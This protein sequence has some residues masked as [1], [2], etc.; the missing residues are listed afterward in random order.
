MYKSIMEK[1][2]KARVMPKISE[3]ERQALEAG[4][5]WIESQ[6]FSGQPNFDEIF[7]QPYASL[8]QREQDFIRHKLP[9]L[10]ALVDPY[11]LSRTKILPEQAV[12]LMQEE[13]FYSFLIPREYGGLEFSAQAISTI[14][15]M[16]AAH[17]PFLSTFVV[18]P[19]SLGAAELL[20]HYGREDQKQ[21]YLPKLA[22]GTYIPC[23]ALTEPLAGS[24]AASIQ[25]QG[26]LFKNQQGQL[27][28]RLNFSKRYI[29]LA[30]IANLISLAFRLKDP[31]LLL[32]KQ[33]DLGITVALVHRGA[34]GLEMGRHHQPI[35]DAFY[36]GP[37]QGNNV[38]IDAHE[39]IGGIDYVGQGWRMLMEQLAGGRAIS[40]PAGAVGTMRMLAVCAGSYAR[41]RHQFDMPIANMEGVQEKLADLAS[42]AYLAEGARIFA[43]SA[44]DNGEKPPIVSAIWKAYLTD[45]S[46]KQAMNAM[47][48]LA[49][50]GVMQGPHNLVGAS[51]CSAPVSIT[52]EGANIMT[53]SLI[54]FGQGAIRCHPFAMNLVDALENEDEKRFK[55]I[56]NHW[57]KSIVTN[58]LRLIVL[59]LTRGHCS[60]LPKINGLQQHLKRLNWASSRFAFLTNMALI[61]VGGKLK[62]RQQLTGYFSDALAWQLLALSSIR[63]YLAEGEIKEDLPLVQYACETALIHIQQAYES[64]YANFSGNKWFSWL[65]RSFGYVFVRLNPLVGVRRDR[66]VAQCAQA[67]TRSGPQMMRIAGELHLPVQRDEEAE[68]LS[69]PLGLQRLLSAFFALEKIESLELIIKQ[70]IKEQKLPKGNVFELAQQ[71]V[72]QG[73]ITSEDKAR[74]DEANRLMMQAI[75]VDSFTPQEF[76]GDTKIQSAPY[77]NS[78]HTP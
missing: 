70:G 17:S 3:T 64:I 66:L 11:L 36:N 38:E 72:N 2:N 55:V 68:Q 22:N 46:R 58:T 25:A 23:F 14:M 77:F 5:T 49:G 12:R 33:E 56:L 41:V 44:I 27:S 63:R 13:G 42:M 4:T 52:V 8:S 65:F 28:I 57:I 40:L 18:I 32:G 74:I 6:I 48:V 24:D 30:P 31:D 50:S 62:S 61:L 15:A 16:L 37:I 43:L 7:I 35:G 20:L 21:H 67:I 54:V 53:R 34:P 10:C 75:Q 59:N 73:L 9:Q 19:N 1:L 29:T 60:K 47:D 69:Y 45:L 71:A 76:F 51:Y 26:V 39:I 78:T